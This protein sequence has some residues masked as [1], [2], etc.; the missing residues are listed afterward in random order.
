MTINV[1]DPETVALVR[2]LASIRGTTLTEAVRIA[3]RN[4]LAED[5]QSPVPVR[6]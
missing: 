3:V 2:K 1:K 5:E 4:K 6:D